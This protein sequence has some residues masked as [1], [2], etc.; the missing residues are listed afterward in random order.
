MC[1]NLT[2]ELLVTKK[3]DQS[4][5]YG[6]ADWVVDYEKIGYVEIKFEGINSDDLRKVF[7]FILT[8]TPNNEKVTIIVPGISVKLCLNPEEMN[9]E[10]FAHLMREIFA[11]AMIAFPVE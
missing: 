11:L 8:L 6:R 1:S 9:Y 5:L 3:N 7:K 10:H 4:C 2:S